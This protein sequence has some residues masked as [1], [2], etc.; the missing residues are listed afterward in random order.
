MRR[1]HNRLGRS[2]FGAH[3]PVMGCPGYLSHPPGFLNVK[4]AKVV[5]IMGYDAVLSLSFANLGTA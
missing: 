4:R 3:T 2:Q 5:T 1:G